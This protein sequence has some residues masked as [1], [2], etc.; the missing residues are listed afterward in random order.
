[1]FLP[2]YDVFHLTRAPDVRLPGGRPVF[3]QVPQRTPEEVL[4]SHGLAP[5]APRLL[6]LA[7]GVSVVSWHRSPKQSQ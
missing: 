2:D 7:S 4:A 6:D 5:G 1:M 3:P